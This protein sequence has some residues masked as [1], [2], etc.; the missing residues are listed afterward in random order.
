MYP[1][2]ENHVIMFSFPFH[3]YVPDFIFFWWCLIN[4]FSSIW[5]KFNKWHSF[6]LQKIFEFFHCRCFFPG[7]IR[8]LESWF[9]NQAL[10]SCPNNWPL[11][12]QS[13]DKTTNCKSERSAYAEVLLLVK[14]LISKGISFLKW[15]RGCGNEQVKQ[16]CWRWGGGGLCWWRKMKHHF[17]TLWTLGSSAI[18]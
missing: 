11:P 1:T 3:K 17:D 18:F 12:L 6:I 9:W 10:V 5:L 7:K 14:H 16:R 15:P 4:I 2:D 8:Q 13:C